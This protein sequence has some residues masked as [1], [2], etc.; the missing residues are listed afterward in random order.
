MRQQPV[1]VVLGRDLRFD[2]VLWKK[3]LE[4]KQRAALVVAKYC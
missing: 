2:H 4:K 3:L 1:G